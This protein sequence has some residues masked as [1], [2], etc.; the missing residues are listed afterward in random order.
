M[1]GPLPSY[2]PE[3]PPTFL[4]QA[5]K[6]AWQRTVPYQM[7]QRG[8]LPWTTSQAGAARRIFPPLDHALVKA[9]ACELVAET[10]QPLSR[11]SLADVTARVRTVLG[12]PISRSTVWRILDTDAIKPWRY[13]YWIFPR[14]PH[15]VDKA[16]PML[17]LYAG[18]WQGKS[19]GP[20]DHLLSAD[21]KTS[22]QARRRCHPSLPPAAGR[23][24][25]IENEY[26]L[27]RKFCSGGHEGTVVP[28]GGGITRPE[29]RT[30][31]PQ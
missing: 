28:V 12:M 21:E 31:R 22:L 6:I 15:F 23:A 26:G 2:R 19:L 24:A 1:R 29:R 14:D 8:T 17:D 25:S 3:F 18:R 11:Q 27:C 5:E 20:K 16:G 13:K 4:E 9:V 7:R 10:Q 30:V